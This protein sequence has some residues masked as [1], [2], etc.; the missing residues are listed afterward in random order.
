MLPLHP[1]NSFT[2]VR[3]I[4]NHLDSAT[5]YVRAV[6][7]NAYTDALITTLDLTDRGGQRFSKN[8]LVPA[9]PSGQG[10]YISIVTS[11][12]TDS[13]YTTKSENYGDD[14]NTY[15]VQDRVPI[16]RGAGGG[17][18]D[19]R[20]LRRI[21][22]EELTVEKEADEPK[23]PEKPVASPKTEKIV[24][25]WDEIL[26]ALKALQKAVDRLPTEK[27]NLEPYSR[28]LEGIMQAIDEKEVTPETDLS[29]I[30]ER[31]DESK[32][33]DGLTRDELKSAIDSVEGNLLEGIEPIIKRALNETKFVSTFTTE[34]QPR[35]APKPQEDRPSIDV[36]QFAA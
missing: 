26:S 11:V 1:G 3:Q 19:A 35:P 31:M 32:E 2:V 16:G 27:L 10:F 4:P 9:D 6:I 30:L 34:A 17:G 28:Q 7:R 13:G 21:I 15:L 8:W 20:T 25:R 5:Y 36:T 23:T 29:P 14:E 33:D 24:M 18:I 22:Q 12:Y